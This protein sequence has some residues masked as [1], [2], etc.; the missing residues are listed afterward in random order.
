M[1]VCESKTAKFL[2][3]SEKNSSLC[4]YSESPTFVYS[5]P[6]FLY[7]YPTFA[8]YCPTLVYSYLRIHMRMH[9]FAPPSP[10]RRGGRDELSRAGIG[11]AGVDRQSS[12]G[13]GDRK[14]R[15]YPS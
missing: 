11:D 13:A 7:F 14:E 12:A 1:K 2:C 6:T 15:I 3:E 9:T 4:V 10:R 8:Y 5:Y